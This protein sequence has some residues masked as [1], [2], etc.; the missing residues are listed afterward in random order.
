MPTQPQTEEPKKRRRTPFKPKL[1]QNGGKLFR[2]TD[3]HGFSVFVPEEL[4]API[5]KSTD[6]SYSGPKI[7]YDSA[8]KLGRRDKQIT[9]GGWRQVKSLFCKIN[10]RDSSECQVTVYKPP[11]DAPLLC[12]PHQQEARTGMTARELEGDEKTVARKALLKKEGWTEFG[13]VHHHCTASAFASGTDKAD[14]AHKMGIHITLGLMDKEELSIDLRM[15]VVVSGRLGE[16]NVVEQEAVNEMVKA[17]MEDWIESANVDALSLP[18]AALARVRAL[19]ILGNE[20]DET[21]IPAGWLD[22]IVPGK[23]RVSTVDTTS[24]GVESGAK[25]SGHSASGINSR[26]IRRNGEDGKRDCALSDLDKERIKWYKSLEGA[27]HSE[28]FIEGIS[29]EDVWD[30]FF[31]EVAYNPWRPALKRWGDLVC[32]IYDQCK[33]GTMENYWLSLRGFTIPEPRSKENN[34]PKKL[35]P[36]G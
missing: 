26:P 33:T 9:L 23:S 5:V 18:D 36:Q 10:D 16:G 12:F 31:V 29:T 13:T 21:V 11:G 8:V 30:Y 22:S 3:I 1:V 28:A 34:P 19:T 27:L 35:L 7:A 14:E 25:E 2:V 32:F 4:E 24:E 6:P 20:R 17:S 15:R